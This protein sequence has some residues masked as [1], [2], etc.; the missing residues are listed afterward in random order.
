MKKPFLYLLACMALIA[1]NSQSSG[2]SNTESEEIVEVNLYQLSAEEMV[3]EINKRKALAESDTTAN[4]QILIDLMEAYKAYGERFPNTAGAPDFTF[5]AGEIAMNLNRTVEA[6]KLFEIVYDEF[7]DYEKRP[8]AL[9]LKAFVLENQAMQLEEAERIYN[10]F[11]EEFPDHP[12]ADDAEYSIKNMGK[13]PEEL[14]REFERQDSI[15][16]AQE[17]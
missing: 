3:T 7:R 12:M 5:R 16:Q 1:C 8:Y 9:F 14:I 17:A 13:S 10:Q 6:I 15:R 11:I 4:K 2:D